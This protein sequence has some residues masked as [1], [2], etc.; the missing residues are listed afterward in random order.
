MLTKVAE[1]WEVTRAPGAGRAPDEPKAT[2]A[3][4]ERPAGK[5]TRELVQTLTGLPE[6]LSTTLG[7]IA[8]EEVFPEIQ[9]DRREHAEHFATPAGSV[10]TSTYEHPLG[11]VFIHPDEPTSRMRVMLGSGADDLAGILCADTSNYRAFEVSPDTDVIRADIRA[12]ASPTITTPGAEDEPAEEGLMSLVAPRRE[13]A[14]YLEYEGWMVGLVHSALIRSDRYG[15]IDNLDRLRELARNEKNP[16]ARQEKEERIKQQYLRLFRELHAGP[17]SGNTISGYDLT[18]AERAEGVPEHPDGDMPKMSV[19]ILPAR[20]EER[21]TT[22]EYDLD[23]ESIIGIHL[24]RFNPALASLL[25]S[26]SGG[27]RT[28]YVTPSEEILYDKFF[29]NFRSVVLT[30]DLAILQDLDYHP[31]EHDHGTPQTS[32]VVLARGRDMI[33][34]DERD[35]WYARRFGLNQGLDTKINLWLVRNVP[36]FKY[37]NKNL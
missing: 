23:N 8:A 27:S 31:G 1:A 10:I 3:P 12:S 7:P 35:W 21:P 14:E 30:P 18:H 17:Q 2:Q 25:K 11:I 34:E 15:D 24:R 28:G 9:A 22:I 5:N 33:A 36:G 16:T 26:E 20:D 29:A 32:F 37:S 13:T 19:R 4:A 6:M